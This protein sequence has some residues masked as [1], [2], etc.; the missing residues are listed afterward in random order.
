VRI[1]LQIPP[2]LVDVNVHPTKMEV[3]FSNERA[4]YHLFLSA[5]RKAIQSQKI[6]PVF[7][8]KSN[9][10]VR[11]EIDRHFKSYR[12]TSVRPAV[13]TRKTHREVPGNQL[14][15]SYTVP[16][17]E[18]SEK[19]EVETVLSDEEKSGQQP[20]LWQVHR[21]YILSQIKSGLVIIDQHVAHER[22]LYEKILKYLNEKKPV[23]SQKLLFP[24]T[25]ELALE[26]YL[27][28]TEI[29]ELLQKIS[30]SITELSGRTILIEGI[31]SD[32]KVGYEAKVLLEIIDYY[33][34]NEGSTLLP[35][36]KIAAAFACKNAIKS[37]EK[38]TLREMS[39]LVDQLFATSEPYFCPHGRPVIVTLNLNEIDK[40]FK[41]M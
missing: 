39:S 26:D 38:L 25:L 16:Q 41:R 8:L 19:E 18:E 33:R 30:F 36:E 31:P 40:K 17:P 28:F 7:N 12:R 20:H 10:S 3:R 32:V 4:I 37:G 24:Q 11:T 35:H 15:F 2:Q 6:I 1:N 13:F 34:E 29:K 9:D 23:P 5:V 22:V 21:R 27:I 14:A